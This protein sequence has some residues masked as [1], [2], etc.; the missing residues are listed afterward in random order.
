MTAATG[1]EP[2]APVTDDQVRFLHLW[3]R[4]LGVRDRGMKLELLSALVRRQVTSSRCLTAAEAGF[5]NALLAERAE[6]HPA[7]S[8][9][10]E[11]QLGA[12]IIELRAAWRQGRAQRRREGRST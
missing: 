5:V 9:L 4:R 1:D 10:P 11:R 3:L 12:L 2:L 8:A 6:T 7:D